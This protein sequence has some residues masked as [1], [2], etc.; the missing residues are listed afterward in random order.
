LKRHVRGIAQNDTVEL[1]GFDGGYCGISAVEGGV[2]NVC[3][4]TSRRAWVR[5]GR[6]IP[7]FWHMIQR[8]NPCLA[9]RLHGAEPASEDI[10]ISNI[11]FA[12]RAPVER[13]IL[14]VGDSAALVSPLVGNGQ[15]M[16]LQAGE[17]V[18]ELVGAYLNGALSVKDLTEGYARQWRGMFAVRLK[19]GRRLQPVFLNS[20]ALTL[21]LR[22]GNRLPALVQWLV[23]S[24]RERAF[25][26]FI[27]R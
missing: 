20:G 27:S 17:L 6:D 12:P 3:L 1:H 4:L 9:E 16:A 2:V 15:A 25:V 11:S 8:E 5:S 24:T 23:H 19:W 22:V 18:S 10:V 14:M 13:D 21:A 26:S 7:A